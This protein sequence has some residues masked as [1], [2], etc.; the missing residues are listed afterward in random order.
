MLAREF[1][2]IKPGEKYDYATDLRRTFDEGLSSS[3]EQKI[4][5]QLPAHVFWDIKKPL[6]Q[7]DEIQVNPY[8]AARKMPFENF[9][10]QRCHEDWLKSK[11][12]KRNID[13]NCSRYTRK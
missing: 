10:E 5:S 6:N 13:A 3:L 4:F 8:N 1:N 9:F 12:E 11:H 2:T 7:P